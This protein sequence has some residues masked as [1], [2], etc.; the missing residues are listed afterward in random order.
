MLNKY[1]LAIAYFI[2][3]C[4]KLMDCLRDARKVLTNSNYH[5][6]KKHY[7]SIPVLVAKVL[8]IWTL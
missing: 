5:T 2:I 7:I 4:F 3:L 1:F 8:L 6:D